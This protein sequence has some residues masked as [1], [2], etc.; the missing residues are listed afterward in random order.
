MAPRFIPLIVTI[1]SLVNF[2][3]AAAE[4]YNVLFLLSDDMRPELGCY[5]APVQSPN[6]DKL[7]A[8]SVRFDRAYCQYPLCNPSRTSLLTGLHPT[9]T[10][11]LDNA[12]NFRK[13]MPEHV[14]LPEL[15]KRN[16]YT[17]VRIGKVYH[18]GIDDLASWSE[19][20]DEAGNRGSANR[21]KNNQ[22]SVTSDCRP[23]GPND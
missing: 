1:L 15:F 4:K 18:G 17:T 10:G 5:G 23:A 6:L 21:K 14:P 12:G 9:Q 2:D 3:L 20:A 11:V 19:G 8:G 13:S 16:G 7:A 22:K